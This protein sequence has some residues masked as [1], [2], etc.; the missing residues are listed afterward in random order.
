MNNKKGFTLI[1]LLAV[2]IILGILMIIAIP[3]VTSYI[4]NSRK[5]AYVDTAKEIVTGTRNTVN[6][7]KLEM[8]ST[9]TTYYIPA[10]YIKTENGLKSPYGDFTEAYVGVT[11]DGKGYNYF[12]V[13]VDDTGQG[14]NKITNID[15]LD[16]D[17]IKSDIKADDIK[18]IVETTGIGS[19]E[20][21]LI[22]DPKTGMWIEPVRE[23]TNYISEEG[24]PIVCKKA[25]TLHTAE[26]TATSGGC[27][28][29]GYVEGNKG[30]TITYGTIP[31]GTPKP[32]DAYDC[33]VTK[34]GGFTERFY[35]VRNTFDG[36]HL[37]YYKNYTEQR[38]VAWDAGKDYHNGPVTAG[39]AL[40]T[41]EEWDNPDIPLPYDWVLRSSSGETEYF[42]D[43]SKKAV[44]LPFIND[45]IS[46]CNAT[47]YNDVYGGGNK[48]GKCNFLLEK[49][50]RYESN[51]GV[52]GYWLFDVQTEYNSAYTVSGTS[53]HV[54]YTTVNNAHYGVR[55]IITINYA[56]IEK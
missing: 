28:T 26:C 2:I 47:R 31:N 50:G 25:K 41:K 21:I 24:Y 39:A 33:K 27:Y 32:G 14:V 49:I 44:T 35:F 12:W 16:E 38:G 43:F 46:G 17:D 54:S 3:S 7:G 29:D 52:E 19:R 23:I 8:Y 15:K 40:P 18:N 10:S 6:E 13:S 34:D 56:S 48:L 1:E 9:D 51:S 42:Y 36:A 37:I 53:V 55:P 11:Y 45:I 5:S 20:K 4:N 30:T 22:L